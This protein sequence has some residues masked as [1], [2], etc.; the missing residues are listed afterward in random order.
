M[1]NAFW[2]SWNACRMRCNFFFSLEVLYELSNGLSAMFCIN[3]KI[4]NLVGD[5]MA[6]QVMLSFRVLVAVALCDNYGFL[7]LTQ[8][9]K[10]KSFIVLRF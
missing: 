1:T 3:F 8:F 6:D 10:V 2:L 7:T 9:V 5:V 4:L